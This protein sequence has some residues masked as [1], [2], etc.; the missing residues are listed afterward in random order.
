M[1]FKLYC[2]RCW[3]ELLEPGGLLFGVPNFTNGSCEKW[4]LCVDC[5]TKVR[6][7]IRKYGNN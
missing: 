4:H 1:A 3:E 7:E 6:N 5:T 2:K